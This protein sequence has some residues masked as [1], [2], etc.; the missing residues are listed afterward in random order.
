MSTSTQP[1]ESLTWDTAEWRYLLREKLENSGDLER[2]EGIQP[3]SDTWENIGEKSSKMLSIEGVM[4][5]WETNEFHGSI[6]TEEGHKLCHGILGPETG[7]LVRWGAGLKDVENSVRF[8][9]DNLSN[10]V[11]LEHI[12]EIWNRLEKV[13]ELAAARSHLLAKRLDLPRR[14]QTPEWFSSQ[15]AEAARNSDEPDQYSGSMSPIAIDSAERLV[16]AVL[17]RHPD[18]IA[19][20]EAGSNG[21]VTIDWKLNSFRL[22]WMIDAPDLSWPSILA[23]QVSHSIP[24]KKGETA[25]TRVLHTAFEAIR[26]FEQHL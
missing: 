16:Q 24:R 25:I 21:R 13:S 15:I 4:E 3:P 22:Q 18:A 6:Q 26:A 12:G 2:R 11:A 14:T 8:A 5:V 9:F 20:V 10:E 1:V 7:P 23:Y 19:R 17:A